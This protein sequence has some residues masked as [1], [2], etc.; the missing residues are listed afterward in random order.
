MSDN[1]NSP[2]DEEIVE[3]ALCEV[4]YIFL[5]PNQL[6]KFIV[7]PNCEKCSAAAKPY[8]DESPKRIG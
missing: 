7:M 8:E 6:Y 2:K 4:P 1:E 3:M 5:R